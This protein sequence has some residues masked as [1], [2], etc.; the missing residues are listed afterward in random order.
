MSTKQAFI[1]RKNYSSSGEQ[2]LIIV[3]KRTASGST[4]GC[5]KHEKINFERHGLVDYVFSQFNKNLINNQ[6]SHSQME[7]DE[8]PGTEYPNKRTQKTEKKTK[9]PPFL[10]LCHKYYKMTKSMTKSSL[11]C[12]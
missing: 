8:T 11:Q 10:T 5:S 9:I 1:L 4:R 12:G 6:V 2:L 7:N 3:S